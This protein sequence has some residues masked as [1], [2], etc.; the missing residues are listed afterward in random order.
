MKTIPKNETIISTAIT[1]CDEFCEYLRCNTLVLNHNNDLTLA[2]NTSFKDHKNR[3]LA[4]LLDNSK[5]SRQQ[6]YHLSRLLRET[7][8]SGK[9]TLTFLCIFLHA[10]KHRYPNIKIVVATLLKL[11][12]HKNIATEIF[13]RLTVS[14]T[15]IHNYHNQEII[16][17]LSYYAFISQCLDYKTSQLSYQTLLENCQHNSLIT[18]SL[19]HMMSSS[20]SYKYIQRHASN[21]TA[22]KYLKFTRKHSTQTTLKTDDLWNEATLFSIKQWLTNQKVEQLKNLWKSIHKQ[23]RK[24]T[25]SHRKKL[26]SA[27]TVNI[28][29]HCIGI[30]PS[31]LDRLRNL[32]IQVSQYQW[33][34]NHDLK[35][36]LLHQPN[37]SPL[38]LT[39]HEDVSFSDLCELLS[40]QPP[41]RMD[42]LRILKSINLPFINKQLLQLTAMMRKYTLNINQRNSVISYCCEHLKSG[43][44]FIT[45]AQSDI[46]NKI[47]AHYYYINHESYSRNTNS[48]VFPSCITIENDPN[49]DLFDMITNL[50]QARNILNKTTL[51][52]NK[53]HCSQSFDDTQIF[54]LLLM[55]PEQ[56]YSLRRLHDKIKQVS[57][58]MNYVRGINSSITHDSLSQLSYQGSKYP[59]QFH[60]IWLGN[61]LPL[62][63]IE[64]LSAICSKARLSHWKVYLHTD[65]PAKQL[66]AIISN[67]PGSIIKEVLIIK[68]IKHL[69]QSPSKNNRT[70]FDNV[71]NCIATEIY[72]A[73]NYA[74]ASDFLRL[75]ALYQ[76]GGLYCDFDCTLQL[77]AIS[78]GATPDRHQNHMLPQSLTTHKRGIAFF[79]RSNCFIISLA[80]HPL[81]IAA[82]KHMSE[83]YGRDL[84]SRAS[85][86]TSARRTEQHN[87]DLS[88]RLISLHWQLTLL[89]GNSALGKTALASHLADERTW[90]KHCNTQSNVYFNSDNDN[91]E[92]DE[93]IVTLEGGLC[94]K[95]NFDGSWVDNKSDN[96]EYRQRNRYSPI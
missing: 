69:Y 46:I 38:S 5:G 83:I 95:H 23:S 31:Q 55:H 33:E 13:K 26:F 90:N 87:P 63:Y 17:Q 37:I 76:Y 54:L 25:S 28:I 79:L 71:Q 32:K 80:Q 41:I 74:L 57:A 16:D 68:N 12:S 70:L 27:T 45:P 53:T 42:L 20:C 89:N 61:T 43:F 21:L 50:L 94:F 64:N 9:Q 2:H 81:L 22:K 30:A 96:V 86:I 58:R 44:R 36:L 10:H 8:F 40:Y 48:F 49:R 60:F 88:C 1:L 35:Q 73:K 56:A 59:K 67:I 93:A 14:F 91:D 51:Y 34:I 18:L 47:I 75:L 15:D 92:P 65:N 19:N 78:I 52:W 84:N 77:P 29:R 66:S 24:K 6:L 7:T 72:S 39:A 4:G 3:H 11:T 62:T 82:L 85:H